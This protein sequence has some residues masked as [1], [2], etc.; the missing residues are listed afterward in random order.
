CMGRRRPSIANWLF[1]TAQRVA[2]DLRRSADRR[3]RREGR[4]AVPE[5]VPPVD[6]MTGR[7][8]FAVLDEE[9]DRLPP[10]YR[11]PLLLYYQADMSREEIAGRLGLPVGTVKIRLERGR[12]KLG[13]ALTRRGVAVSAGLLTLLA[14]SRAGASPPRLV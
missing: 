10:I 8:L 12:K 13:E 9:L 4:A 1:M 7:E 11:E 5:S 14:T 2:R 6:R 3:A